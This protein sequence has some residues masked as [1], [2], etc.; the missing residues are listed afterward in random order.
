MRLV[1]LV[2]DRSV[3]LS[4]YAFPLARTSPPNHPGRAC[5]AVSSPQPHP[6][7]RAVPCPNTDFRS[8]GPISVTSVEHLVLDEGDRLMEMGFLE[9]V[10]ACCLSERLRLP[11]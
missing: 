1:R 9:Q 5:R 3:D 11:S 8:C 6:A 4:R 2:Q 7:A 10:R